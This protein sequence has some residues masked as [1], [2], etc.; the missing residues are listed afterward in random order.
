MAQVVYDKHPAINAA[1]VALQMQ[2]RA[3]FQ[4]GQK[5]VIVFPKPIEVTDGKPRTQLYVGFIPG[6][7]LTFGAHSA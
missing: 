3:A 7:D 1:M 2:L 6:I 4:P 5:G